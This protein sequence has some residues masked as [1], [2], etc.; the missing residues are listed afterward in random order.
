MCEESASFDLTPHDL[1]S[2][3]DII[4]QVLEERTKAAQHGELHLA[5]GVESGAGELAGRAP[6]RARG[7]ERGLRSWTPSR[8][9]A[10]SH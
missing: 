3:L 10:L 6:R 7:G 1:A 9:R 8:R 5:F 4:D 2:G